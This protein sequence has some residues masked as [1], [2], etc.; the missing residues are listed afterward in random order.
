MDAGT[1][2]DGLAAGGTEPA[3]DD[4]AAGYVTGEQNG[5]VPAAETGYSIEAGDDSSAGA[6]QDE[7]ASAE[8]ASQ[9]GSGDHDGRDGSNPG[10]HH[11]PGR[12]DPI[13]A[14]RGF[15]PAGSRRRPVV[16]EEDDDLDVPDFLK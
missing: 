3:A 1:A 11:A 12:L 2:A 7:T 13:T 9:N 6:G 15:D 10:Y 5:H 4:A 14:A 16:F 8:P